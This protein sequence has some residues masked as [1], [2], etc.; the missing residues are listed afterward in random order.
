MVM[1]NAQ[2]RNATRRAVDDSKDWL[3][4]QIQATSPVDTGTYK[5]GW[6]LSGDTISNDV[7]YATQVIGRHLPEVLA[8]Y[9]RYLANRIKVR[10]QR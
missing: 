5:A 1:A 9:P 8:E 10:L 4:H 3:F 2:I 7:E 6:T